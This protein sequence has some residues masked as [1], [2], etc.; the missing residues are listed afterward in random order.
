MPYPII[1]TTENQVLLVG[2][3]DSVRPGCLVYNPTLWTSLLKT[4]DD[5]ICRIDSIDEIKSG[6]LPILASSYPI[7]P[8]I[9]LLPEEIGQKNKRDIAVGLAR[10]AYPLGDSRH[11]IPQAASMRVGFVEGY[12]AAG[13]Y[14]REQ[15][16]AFGEFMRTAKLNDYEKLK[17]E[18]QRGILDTPDRIEKFMAVQNK[19]TND[20]FTV[21][22]ALNTVKLPTALEV[23]TET[24]SGMMVAHGHKHQSAARVFKTIPHP[25]P[26]LREQ[27]FRLIPMT[28]IKMIY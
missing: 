21:W 22:E 19:T 4:T 9:P 26:K 15:M 27:G 8:S 24:P 14:T 13:G 17:E 3:N 7:H 1:T 28:A 10:E 2:T 5:N 18:K 16:I 25:D 20:Y 12:E 6:D 23:E 11:T